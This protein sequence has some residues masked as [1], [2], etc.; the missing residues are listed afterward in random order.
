[1]IHVAELPRGAFLLNCAIKFLV[2]PPMVTILDGAATAKNV[3]QSV[4]AEVAALR[5]AP[6]L[7]IVC[8]GDD[9]ASEI[10]V[11]NKLI[12]AKDVGIGAQ[13]VKLPADSPLETILANIR[14]L[15]EDSA[16]NGIIVQSP[17][18]DGSMQNVAF[19]DICIAKDVDGFSDRSIANLVRGAGN[20]FVP[21][22]PLGICALLEA[23]GIAI[24]GKHIV[25]IGRGSLVGRPLSILLSR[26]SKEFNATVTL[27]HSGTE[28]LVNI[29]RLAD[30]VVVAIGRKF[31]LKRDMVKP[32]AVAIDVGINREACNGASGKYKICGDIDFEN[33]KDIC[34]AITPVP[35]GVGPMTVAMLMRN[36]LFA[37]KEQSKNRSWRRESESN[38]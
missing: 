14:T 4:K 6:Q 19:N 11:R 35:G 13:L 33:V 25:I 32:G 21:C 5:I 28:N 10:Y 7:A 20:G 16:I 36:T 2:I 23:Y 26:K 9:P 31:F 17:L 37:A 8:V 15:N 22:T 38:R 34:Q 27:C 12:Q 3:L 18:P 1:M 29:T 24:G 30:I